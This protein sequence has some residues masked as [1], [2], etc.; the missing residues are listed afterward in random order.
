MRLV[1][2]GLEKVLGRSDM[3]KENDAN[4][5]ALNVHVISLFSRTYRCLCLARNCSK[6]CNVAGRKVLHDLRRALIVLPANAIAHVD[7]LAPHHR[8]DNARRRLLWHVLG[9]R[10]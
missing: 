1:S 9:H 4:S 6:A 8:M 3:Y 5:A 7:Y 2:A 10:K